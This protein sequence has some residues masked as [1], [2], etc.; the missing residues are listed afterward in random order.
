MSLL[1][2]K[3]YCGVT[4]NNSLAISLEFLSS[5]IELIG[6]SWHRGRGGSDRCH[7]SAGSIH[8]VPETMSYMVLLSGFITALFPDI[9]DAV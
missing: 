1:D 8:E 7:P 9:M 6:L 2:L 4:R 5:N 3:L